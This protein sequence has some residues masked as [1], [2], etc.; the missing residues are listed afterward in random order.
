M[1]SP[2]QGRPDDIEA[3]V[4]GG[5]GVAAFFLGN[6]EAAFLAPWAVLRTSHSA[7]ECSATKTLEKHAF[8]DENSLRSER[9]V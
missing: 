3:L 9:S 5:A 1:R 6:P 7:A 8:F 4:S 2:A